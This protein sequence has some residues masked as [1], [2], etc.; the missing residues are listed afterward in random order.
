MRESLRFREEHAEF[1]RV[2]SEF[3][4]FSESEGVVS[5]H[6]TEGDTMKA[7]VE[8]LRKHRE[9]LGDEAMIYKRGPTGWDLF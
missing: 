8:H 5:E 6:D 7:F 4:I 3:V 9:P 2:H 1:L